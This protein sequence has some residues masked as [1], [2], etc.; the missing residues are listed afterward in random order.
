MIFGIHDFTI[1]IIVKEFL[2]E[3]KL[4]KRKFSIAL[5]LSYIDVAQ[6][7]TRRGDKP[8]FS[9]LNQGKEW[10]LHLEPRMLARFVRNKPEFSGQRSCF[11]Y[12]S[13]ESLG[14]GLR[15]GDWNQLHHHGQRDR[16]KT[17]EIDERADI[18]PNSGRERQHSAVQP[19]ILSSTQPHLMIQ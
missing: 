9:F 2:K 17:G 6:P 11:Q 4:F 5:G 15:R 3:K 12:T 13:Q 19:S 8:D 1:L 7:D 18:N 10:H 16:V 14:P